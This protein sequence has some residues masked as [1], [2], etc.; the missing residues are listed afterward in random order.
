[1]KRIL[2]LNPNSSTNITALMDEA[3]SG[4]RFHGGPEIVCETLAEGPAGIETQAHVESVVLPIARHFQ[5][6]VADA[7]V[8]GCF[9]DPGLH[10]SRELVTSP[11]LGIAESAL[12][13]A[14]G[15]GRKFGI[16]AIKQGSIGRHMRIV[17]Q[18]GLENHLAGDRALN[19]GVTQLQ[20]SA[21]T[22]DRIIEIGTQL[23]D[24]DGADVLVLGC[25]SMGTFRAEL[26][27]RLGMPV[28]DPT[29]AAVW[30]AIGLLTLGYK[31]VA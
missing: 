2:V 3:L 6:N 27:D 13:A 22:I 26:E 31:K 8:I 23:R 4:M 20:S 29:Q 9:S 19:I 28:V 24:L 14:L 11:V 1:M 18:M 21:G 10:V 25:S 30:R 15:L 5:K 12:L 7:Y 17:R 16:V